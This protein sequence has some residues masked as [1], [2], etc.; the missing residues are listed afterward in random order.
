MRRE[1][2]AAVFTSVQTAASTLG[3][4]IR[5]ARQ[6]RG[7]TMAEAAERSVMS[8]ATYKRIEAGDPAVA[9]GFVLQVLFQF[10][11]LNPLVDSICPASDPL[12]EALRREKAPKRIRK[13]AHQRVDNDF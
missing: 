1:I 10:D 11:L 13:S 6:A 5:A 12:G 9:S 2:S 3:L 7:W 4:H 8:L